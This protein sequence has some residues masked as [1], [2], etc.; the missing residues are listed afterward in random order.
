MK[1][2]V[3][4]GRW[5]SSAGAIRRERRWRICS[6]HEKWVVL[7]QWA[8]RFVGQGFHLVSHGWGQRWSNIADWRPSHY[9]WMGL[10]VRSSLTRQLALRCFF[11]P[12]INPVAFGWSASIQA[13]VSDVQGN[14]RNVNLA[15]QKVPCRPEAFVQGALPRIQVSLPESL[16]R[17]RSRQLQRRC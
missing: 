10:L 8:N 12:E 11:M 2:R 7:I 5:R 9:S 15:S 17:L 16:E 6:M 1:S 13:M 14:R 4:S 3:S